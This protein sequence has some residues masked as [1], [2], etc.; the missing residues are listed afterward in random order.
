MDARTVYA[1]MLR[2]IHAVAQEGAVELRD[3]DLTPAQFQLLMQVSRRPGV[4]QRQLVEDFGVT[5]GNI[6][7]LVKRL[8]NAGLLSRTRVQGSD[9]LSVTA[10]GEAILSRA[11]PAHEAFM[12]E[13]FAALSSE[14]LRTLH[15]LLVRLSR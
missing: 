11:V 12:A 1:Q 2:F 4:A 13:R 14:E 8:E 7:Q 10:A 9:E 5:K 3:F 15:R 6:S